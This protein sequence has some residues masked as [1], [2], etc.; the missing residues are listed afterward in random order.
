MRDLVVETGEGGESLSSAALTVRAARFDR[1][2]WRICL[3]PDEQRIGD[4]EDHGDNR[5]DTEEDEAV[6]EGRG[7]DIRGHEGRGR[8]RRGSRYCLS[9]SS[10]NESAGPRARA[11]RFSGYLGRRA[12]RPIVAE[13]SCEAEAHE[14]SEEHAR[15]CGG[16]AGVLLSLH[17]ARRDGG[18][19]LG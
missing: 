12:V 8:G 3:P 7:D 1:L 15:W 11:D 6:E 5:G 4:E 9:C 14:R 16:V 17:E 13:A 2:G 10:T 19:V 18:G